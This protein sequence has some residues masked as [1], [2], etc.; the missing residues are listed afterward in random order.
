M[1]RV[2]GYL[3]QL[4]FSC[5]IMERRKRSGSLKC[6][7]KHTCVSLSWLLLPFLAF[8]CFPASAQFIASSSYWPNLASLQKRGCPRLRF[9]TK[10]SPFLG[11]GL[12]HRLP[13]IMLWPSLFILI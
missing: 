1:F 12:E 2:K 6:K 3:G 4:W 13:T 9:C 5:L 10:S 7:R 11:D 8:L